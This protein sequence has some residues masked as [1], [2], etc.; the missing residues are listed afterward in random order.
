MTREQ[1]KQ[2]AFDVRDH[3]L[4]EVARTAI[5]LSSGPDDAAS[6]AIAAT[7]EH[8][9]LYRQAV[10]QGAEYVTWNLRDAHKREAFRADLADRLLVQARDK[11][12]A[13]VVK[14]RAAPKP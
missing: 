12:T 14:K 11:A 10:Q 2:G 3:Y 6:I 1:V 13:A 8:A 9:D 4:A 7:S 5:E